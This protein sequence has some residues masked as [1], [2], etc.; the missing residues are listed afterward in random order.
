[1]NDITW[2]IENREIS[3][4][5][6][7]KINPRRLNKVMGE[8]LKKSLSKFGMCQ[9]IVIQQTNK[10]I[11]G[12]QRLEVLLSLGYKKVKVAVPSRPLTEEESNELTIG[13][14]KIQGEFDFD[15]LANQWDVDILCNAGFT[16]EEL[17]DEV[18]KAEE[19]KKFSITVKCINES[20]L[21]AVEDEIVML[22]GTLPNITYKK[23]IK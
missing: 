12:H 16:L 8:G 9:P 7:N 17:H 19:P 21:R 6:P 1:M 5:I 10:V 2:N 15:M 13:L 18:E 23:K 22:I 11:G 20:E 3:S 14:N 4:L